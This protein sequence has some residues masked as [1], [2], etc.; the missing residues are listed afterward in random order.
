MLA[1]NVKI[2][3]LICSI[4]GLFTLNSLLAAPGWNE[5]TQS[6]APANVN[7]GGSLVKGYHD[8]DSSNMSYLYA[9]MGNS[10][11]FWGFCLDSSYWNDFSSTGDSVGVGGA[12]TY[13]VIEEDNYDYNVL[14]LLVGNLT[15]T[16]KRLRNRVT[17]GIDDGWYGK[18][19]LPTFVDS[20]GS[21]T[22]YIND[23]DSAFVFAFV[24]GNRDSFFRYDVA[25]NDW[26]TMH[27][28]PGQVGYGGA[29]LYNDY[30]IYALQGGGESGFWRY[31]IL[32]DTWVI[33]ASTPYPVGPGGALAYDD[34]YDRIFAFR[35][36]GTNE[37]WEYRIDEDT[38]WIR[39]GPTNRIVGAGGALAWD[40]DNLF[41]YALIGNNTQYFYKYEP[42]E[43]DAKIEAILA[44]IDTIIKNV[45][46]GPQVQV[47]NQGNVN[48]TFWVYFYVFK[49]SDTVYI[50]SSIVQNI[51]PDS[52]KDITFKY[53]QPDTIDWFNLLSFVK[54]TNDEVIANDTT[55]DSVFVAYRDVAVD[56]I[57]SPP[58]LVIPDSH[59][60][61]EI[62]I[63]NHGNIPESLVSGVIIRRSGTLDTIYS[64]DTIITNFLPYSLKLVSFDSCS[65]GAGYYLVKG[66]IVLLG[67]Q[68]RGNDT[69]CKEILLRY[70]DI[71]VT[72]ISSPVGTIDSTAII[73]TA[74]IENL[75]LEDTLP[76]IFTSTFRIYRETNFYMEETTLSIEPGVS[77]DI[78]FP[79]CTLPRDSYGVEC[80][81]FA[82][83][84]TNDTNNILIDS[85][86]IVVRDIGVYQILSPIDTILTGIYHPQ[87]ILVKY[88]NVSINHPF[89]VTCNITYSDTLVY[90]D[91]VTLDSLTSSYIMVEFIKEWQPNNFGQYSICSQ[92]WDTSDMNPSNDACEDSILIELR[93]I[94]VDSINLRDTFDWEFPIVCSTKVANI[95]NAVRG[96][97]AILHIDT[98]YSDTVRVENL[99]PDSTRWVE[100]DTWVAVVGG[101]HLAVCST[102]IANDTVPENDTKSKSFFVKFSDVGTERIIKPIGLIRF[103]EEIQPLA[104]I[105]N[106]GFYSVTS[107]NCHLTITQNGAPFY[108]D[109]VLVDTINPEES[110]EIAFPL[111]PLFTVDNYFAC[112]STELADA[113][114]NNDAAG[115]SFKIRQFPS[116]SQEATGFNQNRH[117]VK[118]PNRDSLHLVFHSNDTIFYAHFEGGDWLPAETVGIGKLPCISLD[119][120]GRPWIAYLSPDNRSLNCAVRRDDDTWKRMFIFGIDACG[121][122]A[123]EYIGQPSMVHN[124]Y[125]E[126][127]MAYL[128]CAFNSS[129]QNFGMIQFIPFDTTEVFYPDPLD[130]GT[131]TDNLCNPSIGITPKDLL[132]V[133][134][135][136]KNGERQSIFYLVTTEGITPSLIYDREGN[137]DWSDRTVVSTPQYPTT[138]PASNP[139]VE[140]YGDSVFVAWRGPNDVGNDIGEIWKRWK[141]ALPSAPW[142]LPPRNESQT[143]TQDSDYLVM[144]TGE[145]TAWHE[146][147]ASNNWEIFLKI[148]EENPTNVS[149][150]PTPS[151]YPHIATAI[152]GSPDTP[153]Q[154]VIDIIWTELDS[155]LIFYNVRHERVEHNLSS[156]MGY[157]SVNVGE[158][159]PSPYLEEREGYLH[160]E[161]YKI[162]YGR[163][164]L[165]YKLP[166]LN[167]LYDYM[168][169]AVVFTVNPNR[170]RQNFIFDDSTITVIEF[171]PFKPETLWIQIPQTTYKNDLEVRERINRLIG[172]FAVLA[173]LQIYQYE[174]YIG[175]SGKGGAMGDNIGLTLKPVLYNCLPNPFRS[176]TMI[177][178]QLPSPALVSLKV[179]DIMGKVVR[180]LVNCPQE[181][182]NYLIKWDGKDNEGKRL[183]NGIYF[184][185][186]KIK[187]FSAIKKLVLID[188]LEAK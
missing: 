32:Q 165:C 130:I 123:P 114:S 147:L 38:W 90:S 180:N 159:I 52:T 89:D 126:S 170:T 60:I 124:I 141:W 85:V 24:G 40:D 20:G 64:D 97:D 118:N 99:F 152:Y 68:N 117:L 9:V 187:G 146:S 136:R 144:S 74:T 125:P 53:W 145:V 35:G 3:L 72:N 172:N 121:E 6:P 116:Y 22:S 137:L 14:Y 44:P 21:L 157:Y 162:D 8:N 102:K 51:E 175:G 166:Y 58:S 135:Q 83:G 2:I 28:A 71:A 46:I 86:F 112:C 5:L 1:K 169:R 138:E 148:R 34:D 182:G 70:I 188:E 59:F 33:L 67:D 155:S 151:K 105:K 84:D 80:R 56:S 92:T 101:S 37:F 25:E 29:L 178:Y 109:D 77:F 133:A 31:D 127:P 156:S 134:W 7:D 132:H 91:T 10:E 113:N 61:P 177:R 183:G 98:V 18:K 171:E 96:F 75:I 174:E 111:P 55:R 63:H 150:T 184:Y 167:P 129:S 88:G 173:D 128:V 164:R 47:K 23:D 76:T 115:D 176:Q 181:A 186:L 27:S 122:Y 104:L 13:I 36:Q 30:F 103:Q 93:D 139:F 49:E 168:A 69:L 110:L 142:D 153:Q 160:Y 100:F 45:S 94:A 16:F 108:V 161:Q 41:L 42:I 26:D 158:S 54:N 143:E 106:Y 79:C 163:G 78:E 107:L 48:D 39:P 131:I 65:L 66:Y 81:V 62:K 15:T 50:D 154:M 140:A 43:N 57:L 4:I 82:V 17:S 11:D 19:P 119:S 12:L 73:P 120:A 179:Y 87:V 185:T 95:G 149:N